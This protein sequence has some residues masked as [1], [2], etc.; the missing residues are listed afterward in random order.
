MASPSR[1]SAPSALSAVQII[2]IWNFPSILRRDKWTG[3]SA[4][5]QGSYK[6]W[7]LVRR[8]LHGMKPEPLERSR[9]CFAS[10]I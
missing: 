8:L 4:A 5:S 9:T 2:G 10:A 1:P 6:R 3:V 7:T